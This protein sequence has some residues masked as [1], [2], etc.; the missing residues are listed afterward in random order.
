MK[1]ALVHD[2]LNEFGGA[3]RVLLALSDMY[4][5]APIY[6][7]FCNENSHAGRTFKNKKIIESWFSYLPYSHKLIS[8]LRFLIPLIWR[9][10]DFSKYDLVITSASWAVTKGMN[11]TPQR[12]TLGARKR[13]VEICYLHTPPRYLWGYDTSRNWKGKWYGGIIKAYSLVVN[14]FMRIYDFQKAQKVTYFIANSKN[15]GKRIEKFYRRK[16]Y[17]VVY[18]PV[19]F[20]TSHRKKEFPRGFAARNSFL[21]DEKYYLTGG[22]MTAAKNFDKIIKACK[23]ANVKLVIFG[24]GVVE[25]ELKSLVSS[26]RRQGT[27][28]IQ[29]LGRVSDE[30][31]ASLYKNAKAF[32]VAQKDEDFG[33]TPVEA[34]LF[35]TPTIAY[36]A[37][38][39][40]ESVVDGKTGL[41]FD[42]LTPENIAKAIKKSEKVKWN[43]K[44]IKKHAEKFSKERFE[45]EISNIVSK[46]DQ[47]N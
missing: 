37:E 8:P 46:Y 16:D 47:K 4:P 13:P 3:E 12:A 11:P 15:V 45:R 31:L 2:Y 28:Q 43:K 19:N 44:V 38:G 35:G 22:R 30:E 34:A 18:P 26:L 24:T 7:I 33:L 42:K 5:E 27:I 14:H 36:K 40:L 20:V 21:L 6:T 29:F 17:V 23:L 25:N 39:Y 1:V 41:F 32:I 10:F 9:S